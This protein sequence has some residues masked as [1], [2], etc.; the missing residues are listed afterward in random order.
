MTK[1]VLFLQGAGEGAHSEDKRLADSL[2]RA[3]GAAY[4]VRYPVMPDEGDAPYEPWKQHVETELAT[5]S[6]PV[7]LVG[8]SIGA[9]TLAKCLTEIALGQ[10]VAGIF[11]ISTP[12]W[13]GDGWR[14]EGYQQLEL[15]QDVAAR[16]PQDAPIFLYHSHDDEIVPFSHLALY[17][18]LLPKATVR[19]IESGGHQLNNDLTLVAKDIMSVA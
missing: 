11:L 13:G 8:H 4:D 2:R 15:P 14:Y 16:L 17:A 7:I 10:P 3:L 9:H 18:H 19:E 12:F 1:Q 6:G 5:L